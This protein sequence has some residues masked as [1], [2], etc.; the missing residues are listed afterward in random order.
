M[1]KCLTETLRSREAAFRSQFQTV[2]SSTVRKM[3]RLRKPGLRQWELVAMGAGGNGSWQQWELAVQLVH[4]ADR[5][6]ESLGQNEKQTQPSRPVP[7]NSL[8]A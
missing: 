5:D 7:R 4:V 1:V 6:S 8:L 2:W 3:Q